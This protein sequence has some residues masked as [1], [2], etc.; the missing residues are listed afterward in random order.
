MLGD[1]IELRGKKKKKRTK[2]ITPQQRMVA[3]YRGESKQVAGVPVMKCRST[4]RFRCF[5]LVKGGLGWLYITQTNSTSK[6]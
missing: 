3:T 6:Y 4:L 2:I 5:V 1:A